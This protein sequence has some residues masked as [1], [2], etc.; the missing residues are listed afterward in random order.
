MYGLFSI[1]ENEYSS[2]FY[3]IELS[4]V[5][6]RTWNK[7]D[8]YDYIL[9]NFSLALSSMVYFFDS[10]CLKTLCAVSID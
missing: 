4:S 8:D 6:S 2:G 1:D 7:F 3:W 10:S 5:S 9:K